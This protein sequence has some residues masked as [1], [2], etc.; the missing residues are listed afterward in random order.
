VTSQS[1]TILKEIRLFENNN[2]TSEETHTII[3]INLKIKQKLI[4]LIKEWLP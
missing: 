2:L 4:Q 3:I 1:K